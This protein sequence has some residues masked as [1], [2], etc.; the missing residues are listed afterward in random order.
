MWGYSL[1]SEEHSPAAL[2]K[3]AQHAEAAGFDFLSISDHFHPWIDEQGH[4]PFVWA[5]LG[6]VAQATS[7]VRVGTGVT[8]PILRTHPAVIAHAAATTAVLFE[9]RFFFGVGTGEALNEHVLGQRWPTVEIRQ[10]ML[11]EAM[12]VMREL[13]KGETVDFHGQY[14][15]VENARLYD[16]PDE[17]IPVVVSA[18][19][20]KAAEL[21]ARDGD[22]IW[23]TSPRPDVLDAFRKAKGTGP[24]IGQLTLCWAPTLDEAVAT[25]HRVW[26]N[27]GLP[28][29]LAQDLPTPSHFEQVT[30][31]VKPEDLAKK[32]PCGP[33]PDPVVDKL[34]E[35]E[36]A[37]LDHV[38]LHQI[39]PDQNGFLRFWEREI[40]PKL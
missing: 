7:R 37:G 27:T 32:I 3:N 28:G 35:Y 5:V 2:V 18:F 10:A 20:P 40:A 14:Y 9:G 1:S 19:G 31:L 11:A 8:C 29:Q 25:A 22:G 15:T 21:A 30:S 12:K 16:V 13:W 17:P 34:R 36:K 24:R 38:H 6:A 23:M 4:S 26:P 33:D 39:G